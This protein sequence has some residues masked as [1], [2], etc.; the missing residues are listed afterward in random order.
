MFIHLDEYMSV[1]TDKD[2][3]IKYGGVEQR[4]FIHVCMRT[5]FKRYQVFELQLS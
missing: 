1:H 3:F 4:L 2:Y 5:N